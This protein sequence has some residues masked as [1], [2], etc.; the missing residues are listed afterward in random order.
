MGPCWCSRS[1]AQS[2][3]NGV[4]VESL[5]L[6]AQAC[7]RI[8]KVCD[9]S[10]VLCQ[11]GHVR[12]TWALITGLSRGH[13]GTLGNYIVCIYANIQYLHIIQSTN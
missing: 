4:H 5:K 1:N 12:G 6:Q 9:I 10:T 11:L 7:T 3:Y 2:G 13:S 8:V